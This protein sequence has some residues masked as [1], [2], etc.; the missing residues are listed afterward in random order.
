M[1]KKILLKLNLSD[2]LILNFPLFN[3]LYFFSGGKTCI[4]CESKYFNH[5]LEA[6]KFFMHALQIKSLG[7]CTWKFHFY[8][9]K[10]NKNI[11]I[12]CKIPAFKENRVSEE[13]TYL[14]RI[15]K[16][17]SLKQVSASNVIICLNKVQRKIH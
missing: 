7:K 16:S 1:S 8:E 6:K 12:K 2:V 13:K 3:F 9:T 17:W 14:Q 15:I 4:D 5:S 11:F 10:Q